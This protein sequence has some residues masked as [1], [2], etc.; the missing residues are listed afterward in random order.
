MPASD[1]NDQKYI[2]FKRETFL[3]VCD[4]LRRGERFPQGFVEAWALDDAVVIRR[5]D[6]FAP[7]ALDIYA[8]TIS[9]V[10]MREQD[11]DVKEELQAIAD[12][13]FRQATIAQDESYKLPTL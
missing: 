1:A 3:E 10:A 2:T 6:L 8:R 5:Q 12:Y 7:A 9:L 13:F 11:K 4:K